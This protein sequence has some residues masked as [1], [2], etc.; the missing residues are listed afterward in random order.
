[1]FVPNG[2][3]EGGKY[4]SV[5]GQIYSGIKAGFWERSR[6][7]NVIKRGK[8]FLGEKGLVAPKGWF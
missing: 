5:W 6:G 2:E 7:V 3:K 4:K 8:L 1:V